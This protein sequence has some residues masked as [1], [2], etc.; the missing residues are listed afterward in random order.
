MNESTMLCSNPTNLLTKKRRSLVIVEANAS[1]KPAV[2]ALIEG[3][4]KQAKPV[5]P[6][7]PAERRLNR[8]DSHRLTR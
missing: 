1:A 3:V 7:T 8:I 6:T 2:D 4:I 5:A